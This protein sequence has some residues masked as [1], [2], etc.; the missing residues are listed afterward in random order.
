MF[1]ISYSTISIL[2]EHTLICIES[3]SG[4]MMW[5]QYSQSACSCWTNS[6]KKG[7]CSRRYAICGASLM[8][9][10]FLEVNEL[11]KICNI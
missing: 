8:L 4:C 5:G 6:L 11:A 1:D 7:H 3:K 9:W 10:L 2:V